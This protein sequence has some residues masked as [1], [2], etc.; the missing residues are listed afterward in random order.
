MRQLPLIL[1]LIIAA[2]CSRT[3][4]FSESLDEATRLIYADEYYA[5]DEILDSIGVYAEEMPDSQRARYYRLH[6]LSN[7]NSGRSLAE[8]TTLKFSVE[9]Y[10]ASGDSELTHLSEV[11]YGTALIHS[12]LK[13]G[14]VGYTYLDSLAAASLSRGDTVAAMDP[15]YEQ[16]K[17][18]QSTGLFQ[19]DNAIEKLRQL[20]RLGAALGEGQSVGFCYNQLYGFYYGGSADAE[21]RDSSLLFYKRAINSCSTPEDSSALYRFVLRNYVASLMASNRGK[22]AIEVSRMLLDRMGEDSTFTAY[23]V[24]LDLGMAYVMEGVPDSARKYLD[25]FE[26]TAPWYVVERQHMGYVYNTMRMVN[27]YQLT[28]HFDMYEFNR[29]LHYLSGS[30]SFMHGRFTQMER[31]K[32]LNVRKEYQMKIDRQR[33]DN[34]LLVCIVA[35]VIVAGG[36]VLYIR[37]NRREVA[38]KEE[39]IESLVAEIK[40]MESNEVNDNVVKRVMLQQLGILKLVASNPTTANQELLK[41]I[42][43][44]VNKEVDA[45]ALLDWNDIYRTVDYVYDGFYTK[46]SKNHGD[47]LNEQELRLCCLLKAGFSTKEIMLVTQQSLQT[48]YQRKSS[49]RKKTGYPDILS[50]GT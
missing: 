35:L 24:Y 48:V 4:K 13:Y 21:R 32:R 6:A 25:E 7:Q 42:M 34:Q 49:I 10:R 30:E 1:V 46:L 28:G 31:S 12:H 23:P 17:I 45:D 37:R 18:F 19:A 2:G 16:Y 41:G 8:D 38:E 9:Y 22:K 44:V 20:Q 43:S 26:R 50:L 3:G 47:K 36:I 15:L 29:L 5:A 27:D 40:R 11:L 33:R 14:I 39:Q